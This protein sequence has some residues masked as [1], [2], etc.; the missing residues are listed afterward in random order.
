MR[1]AGGYF[2]NGFGEMHSNFNKDTALV[3]P[4]RNRD[5]A[6]GRFHHAIVTAPQSRRRVGNTRRDPTRTSAA[7]STSV[8]IRSGRQNIA[9]PIPTTDKH[10]RF[11]TLRTLLQ[12]DY[13]EFP[14]P[15]IERAERVEE[16]LLAMKPEV[17]ELFGTGL[18][19]SA[20]TTRGRSEDATDDGPPF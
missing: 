18:A 13:A 9:A 10:R 15:L 11:I 17:A 3:G 14:L 2:A 6:K 19:S 8:D 16:L 4:S 5:I 20:P 7:A 12:I 1:I